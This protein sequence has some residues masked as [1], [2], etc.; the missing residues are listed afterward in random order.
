MMMTRNHGASPPEAGRFLFGSGFETGSGHEIDRAAGHSSPDR[1]SRHNRGPTS[2]NAP[3]HLCATPAA[4]E[5]HPVGISH[6]WSPEGCDATEGHKRLKVTSAPVATEGFPDGYPSAAISLVSQ[7]P[8]HKPRAETRRIR[9]RRSLS[10][11]PLRACSPDGRDGPPAILF[12]GIRSS[13]RAHPFPSGAPEFPWSC[14]TL[15]RRAR[16]GR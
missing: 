14:D 11:R 6:R 4:A 9:R 5:D 3:P 12:P 15:Q 10:L 7:P 1:S 16:S 2:P 8:R 13:P